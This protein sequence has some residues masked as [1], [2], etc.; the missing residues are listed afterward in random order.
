MENKELENIQNDLVYE[1]KNDVEKN[2]SSTYKTEITS[3]VDY[4]LH[5]FAFCQLSN[6][7]DIDQIVKENI[8][9]VVGY[10]SQFECVEMLDSYEELYEKMELSRYLIRFLKEEESII[11]Q[12]SN[13]L[14][15]LESMNEYRKNIFR[16][17]IEIASLKQIN[18]NNFDE[19]EKIA[20][21]F[22]KT[23][24][25]T[26]ELKDKVGDFLLVLIYRNLKKFFFKDSIRVHEN[27]IEKI[28]KV[29]EKI[30]EIENLI[31]NSN[32]DEYTIAKRTVWEFKK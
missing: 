12:K 14:E 30:M 6:Q 31:R 13:H 5:A 21:Y 26:I 29:H 9:K 15:A 8:G 1:F 28:K 25:L 20:D 4:F 2:I 16:S 27:K 11:E 18:E 7:R 24:D 19:L 23:L 3:V 32:Q 17:S 22:I 10:L